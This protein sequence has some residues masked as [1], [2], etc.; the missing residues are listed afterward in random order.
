MKL[1]DINISKAFNFHKKVMNMIAMENQPFSIVVDNGF[2]EL[3]A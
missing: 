1:W 2:I 3:L